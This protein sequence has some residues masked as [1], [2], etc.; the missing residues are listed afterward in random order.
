MRPVSADCTK[1]EAMSSYV[2]IRNVPEATRGA[3]KARAAAKGESLNTYLLNL[4]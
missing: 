2:Q 4:P 1:L 3:L